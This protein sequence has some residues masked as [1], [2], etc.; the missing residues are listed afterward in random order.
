MDDDRYT[1]R[2]TPRRPG[3]SWSAVNIRKV[4]ALEK[5]ALMTPRGLSAFDK[6]SVEGSKVY[7]YERARVTLDSLYEQQIR[8][9]E[10]AWEF[11]SA[12]APYNKKATTHWVMGAK[13]DKRRRGNVGLGV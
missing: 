1:V 10:R 11:W 5:K 9:D 4:A 3:S 12:L 6:K 7:A 2:F 13:Q 8:R